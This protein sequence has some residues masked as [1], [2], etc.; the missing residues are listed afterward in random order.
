MVAVL[1]I[2]ILLST[3]RTLTI[4]ESF[5]LLL[6]V[7]RFL[8]AHVLV[9]S[10]R[11]CVIGPTF[12][13]N[14]SEINFGDVGFGELPFYLVYLA[15]FIFK[16]LHNIYFTVCIVCTVYHASIH[17]GLFLSVP[18][19]LCRFPKNTDLFPLQ[20]LLCAYDLCPACPGWR[21]WFS[22]C[23]LGQTVVWH[24]QEWLASQWCNK[25]HSCTA[26]WVHH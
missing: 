1:L 9:F 13:F 16:L 11:G 14:V 8:K 3:T 6:L 17:R 7:S 21:I 20:H 4:L 26:C 24:V 25:R 15:S 19:S 12:H 5:I 2:E 22:Q 23:N 10:F 18:I